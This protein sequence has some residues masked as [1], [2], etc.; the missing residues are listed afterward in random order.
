MSERASSN[1]YEKIVEVTREYLGPA[2]DR[3][4]V[5]QIAN[6]IGKSPDE[7]QPAD[8]AGLIDWLKLSMAFLT[9]DEALIERYVA[10]LKAVVPSAKKQA[11]AKSKAAK[12][13]RL[14]RAVASGKNKT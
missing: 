13:T 11:G 12:I 1:L 8:V 2:A 9:N 14:R 4:I 7:L 5:R 6:H 10:E 3:F